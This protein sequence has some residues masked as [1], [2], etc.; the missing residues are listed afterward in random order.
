MISDA[1]QNYRTTV[2]N[3]KPWA[4]VI[5]ASAYGPKNNFIKISPITG[6]IFVTS[7]Y[8]KDTP[9]HYFG[10]VVYPLVEP[11]QEMID[12]ETEYGGEE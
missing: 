6:E 10:S 8:T 9:V 11:G 1:S 12:I 7:A 3:H 5:M 2:A 4:T